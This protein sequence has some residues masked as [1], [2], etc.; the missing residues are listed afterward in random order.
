MT[1]E[2]QDDMNKRRT[3]R[4]AQKN[5]R[6]YRVKIQE[7]KITLTLADTSAARQGKAIV[8]HQRQVIHAPRLR[9][10]YKLDGFTVP[11]GNKHRKLG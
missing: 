9:L 6:L 7:Q 2:R 3:S 4:R 11:T 5:K 10:T 1:V 8:K